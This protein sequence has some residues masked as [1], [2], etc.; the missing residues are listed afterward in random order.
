MEH[1]H[2]F[3]PPRRIRTDPLAV[4][5]GP[6]Y[7]SMSAPPP[8]VVPID[9]GAYNT[10]PWPA[11]SRGPQYPSVSTPPPRI[12]PIDPEAYYTSPRHDSGRIRTDS[13]H[14][15]QRGRSKTKI[16][17]PRGSEYHKRT[18]YGGQYGDPTLD[19]RHTQSYSYQPTSWIYEDTH[20]PERVKIHDYGA[21]SPYSTSEGSASEDEGSLPPPFGFSFGFFDPYEKSQESFT[22]RSSISLSRGRIKGSKNIVGDESKPFRERLIDVSSSRYI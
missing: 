13:R 15:K 12:V 17:H 7:P 21:E 16:S 5:R 11:V 19:P 3:A 14:I 20:G 10:P 8:R 2:S 4:S 22:R 18:S 1:P 9:P 6:Q